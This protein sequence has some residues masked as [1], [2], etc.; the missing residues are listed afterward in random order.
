MKK[1]AILVVYGKDPSDGN[2]SVHRMCSTKQI[3]AEMCNLLN[4]DEE[5]NKNQYGLRHWYCVFELTA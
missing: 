3:A 2:P 1:Y 4:R 5:A